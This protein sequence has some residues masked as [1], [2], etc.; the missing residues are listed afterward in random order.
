M[1]PK[2]LSKIKMANLHGSCWL[3]RKDFYHFSWQLEM[4]P[5]HHWAAGLKMCFTQGKQ[6]VITNQWLQ[7]EPFQ[8]PEFWQVFGPSFRPACKS[9]KNHCFH[10][11]FF[12]WGNDVWDHHL[13]VNLSNWSS[14]WAMFIE[15][16]KPPQHSNWRW[17]RLRLFSQIFSPN[18]ATPYQSASSLASCQL[19]SVFQALQ[20]SGSSHLCDE[21]SHNK[22]VDCWS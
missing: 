18:L 7:Y 17:I 2:W 3:L 15:V 13:Q 10:V 1:N 9:M 4:S 21:S 11:R 16:P 6:H 12:C 14:K 20:F 8:L 22:T 5:P 19:T